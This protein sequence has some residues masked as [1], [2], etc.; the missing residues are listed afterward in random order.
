MSAADHVLVVHSKT[1]LSTDIQKVNQVYRLPFS[2]FIKTR[3][4]L[5]L[6][7]FAANWIYCSVCIFL[8][9][10]RHGISVIYA[11]TF[12]ACLFTIFTRTLINLKLIA[13]LRDN[14]QPTWQKRLL[15]LT[16]QVITISG[17]IKKQLDD[18]HNAEIVYPCVKPI[19]PLVFSEAMKTTGKC[20]LTVAAIGQLVPW[21]GQRTFLKLADTFKFDEQV[22]F[23]IIGD[24][25]S[26]ANQDYREQIL[27]QVQNMSN[28]TYLG[29][30]PDINRVMQ[31]I[32]VLVHMAE[33]E[34]FGRVIVEAMLARKT[35]I[36]LRS[37]GIPEIIEH[38]K[39]GLLIAKEQAVLQSRKAILDLLKSPARRLKIG[40]AALKRAKEFTN[41]NRHT[42]QVNQILNAVHA[43]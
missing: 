14:I 11:N 6:I 3:N 33:G 16:D 25:Q 10:K 15:Y 21:K 34:P 18:S 19:E 9:A 43:S 20:Q 42:Y 2:W 28:V 29:Q 24:D 8:I 22:N 26:Q 23:L 35:V 39:N 32:D 30:V 7:Y 4:P 38:G 5:L 13:C 17:H 12:K 40:Q 31:E 1:Q 36:A 27:K 41:V 37:G